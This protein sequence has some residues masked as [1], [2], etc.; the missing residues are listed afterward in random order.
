MAGSSKNTNLD[1][2]TLNAAFVLHRRYFNFQQVNSLN[3]AKPSKKA[4]TLS[5][6]SKSLTPTP[7]VQNY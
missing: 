1:K 6:Y 2:K 3:G 7:K 4:T 5:A